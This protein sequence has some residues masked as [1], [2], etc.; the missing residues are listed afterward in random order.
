[1]KK[2]EAMGVK[3]FTFDLLTMILKMQL[4]HFNNLPT[5]AQTSRPEREV[6]DPLRAITERKHEKTEGKTNVQIQ[7]MKPNQQVGI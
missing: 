6:S 3:S 7:E 1:M 5:A 4:A 2:N